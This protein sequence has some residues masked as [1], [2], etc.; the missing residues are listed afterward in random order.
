M[1]KLSKIEPVNIQ[2]YKKAWG[3]FGKGVDLVTKSPP[4]KRHSSGKLKK[5]PRKKKEANVS[6]GAIRYAAQR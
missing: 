5:S 4:K 1:A 6:I 2:L 3:H